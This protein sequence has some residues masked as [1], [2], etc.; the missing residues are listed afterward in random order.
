MNSVRGNNKDVICTAK[1]INQYFFREVFNLK[2]SDGSPMFLC[3]P[4]FQR[5]YCW[6]HEQIKRLISDAIRLAP[7]AKR[8]GWLKSR[9]GVRY[10]AYPHSLGTLTCCLLPDGNLSV[11]DGQQRITTLCL[12]LSSIRDYLSRSGMASELCKEIEKT[13]FPA[14]RASGCVVRPTYFDRSSFERCV[15]GTFAQTTGSTIGAEASAL[16]TAKS[17]AATNTTVA[18]DIATVEDNHIVAV[19]RYLDHLIGSRTFVKR[20]SPETWQTTEAVVAAARKLV[21]A[22]L[23]QFSCLWFKMDKSANA[24]SA[25]ARLAMRAAGIEILSRNPHAGVA[26]ATTDL[27]RNLVVSYFA[28]DQEVAIAIYFKYWAPVEQLAQAA[29]ARLASKAAQMKHEGA[30]GIR[31]GSQMRQKRGTPEDMGRRND[32]A[33]GKSKAAATVAQLNAL[34][35]AFVGRTAPN[36]L[37]QSKTATA[38]MWTDPCQAMF[39]GYTML[40]HTFHGHLLAQGLGPT[41]PKSSED[42]SAVLARQLKVEGVVEWLL[43]RFMSFAKVFFDLDGSMAPPLPRTNPAPAMSVVAESAASS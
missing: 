4:I 3:V 22:A 43:Q 8:A 31:I 24:Q 19:R 34:I 6:G 23:D 25:Y 10:R 26:M 32:K 1:Q 18:N 27:L 37:K 14:G 28:R 12:L 16:S 2:K 41:D 20:L 30:R 9:T 39:P 38:N 40:Q 33:A 17:S 29:G 7:G 15:N 35:E 5:R 13:L 11:I 36:I 42:E 21:S